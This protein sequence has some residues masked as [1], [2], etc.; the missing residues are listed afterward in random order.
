VALNKA[1]RFLFPLYLIV[2]LA[3]L[4]YSSMI[5]VFTPMMMLDHWGMV[6]PDA[7]EAA[8][9]V[10]LGILLAL[11]PFGQFFG[12]PLLIA[13]SRRFHKKSILLRHCCIIHFLV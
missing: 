8:R 3:S 6:G 11:Y 2:F 9:M 12:S 7:S 10:E 13:L 4:G 1:R 5:A